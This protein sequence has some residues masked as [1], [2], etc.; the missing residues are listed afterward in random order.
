MSH[1]ADVQKLREMTSDQHTDKAYGLMTR[2][3]TG[4]SENTE[5]VNALHAVSHLLLAAQKR[6][7]L[8]SPK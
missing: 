3:S 2:G 5:L 7:E 1:P 8:K 6:D 4:V